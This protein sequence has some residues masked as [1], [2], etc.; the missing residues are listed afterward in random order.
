ME[1]AKGVV[2]LSLVSLQGCSDLVVEE[3]GFQ[4][5]LPTKTLEQSEDCNT[6]RGLSREERRFFTEAKGSQTKDKESS[7]FSSGWDSTSVR[8]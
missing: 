8:A 4:E 2:S 6:A 1:I 7:F 3:R 5:N